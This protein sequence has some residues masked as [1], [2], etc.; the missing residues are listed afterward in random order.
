MIDAIIKN[1]TLVPIQSIRSLYRLID[2]VEL[3]NEPVPLQWQTKGKNGK[4]KLIEDEDILKESNQ[5]RT[6]NRELHRG[7]QNE[8]NK[9][10]AFERKG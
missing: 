10:G 3:N 4:H 8:D 7:R 6:S 2:K 1:G 9:S 5:V